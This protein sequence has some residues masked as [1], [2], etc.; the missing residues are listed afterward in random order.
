MAQTGIVAG[1]ATD[2]ATAA[3]HSSVT[4]LLHCADGL[5]CTV[6]FEP[7]GSEYELLDEDWLRVQLGG[8]LGGT[9]EVVH[10]PTSI[11]LWP[12]EGW[13]YI[14]AANRLGEQQAGLF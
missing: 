11:L 10:H 5:S 12:G 4:L 2:P 1:S 7:Y 6:L 14:A 3:Q 9:I 13:G 8:P